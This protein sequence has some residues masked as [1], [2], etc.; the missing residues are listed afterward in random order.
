[1]AA[2]RWVDNVFVELLWRSVKHEEVCLNAYGLVFD[3]KQSLGKYFDFHPTEVSLN[4]SFKAIYVVV[5]AHRGLVKLQVFDKMHSETCNFG[6]LIET[7]ARSY[8]PAPA[9]SVV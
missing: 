7:Q 4:S 2:G 3:V 6:P 8:I 9:R 1:M 5:N